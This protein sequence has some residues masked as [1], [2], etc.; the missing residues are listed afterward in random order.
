MKLDIKTNREDIFEQYLL[1]INPI[2]HNKRLTGSEIKILSKILYIYNMY[3]YLG[4][5]NANN[6]VFHTE[7]KKRIRESLSKESKKIISRASFDNVICSLKSKGFITSNE[8]LLLVPIKNGKI[9]LSINLEVIQDA[10]E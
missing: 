5:E 4:K 2:L 8:V 6:I 9:E 10:E 7:T 3:L 1:L